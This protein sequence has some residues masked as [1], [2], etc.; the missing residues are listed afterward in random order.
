VFVHSAQ[1]ASMKR[2]ND[3]AMPGRIN[4][5]RTAGRTI[6]EAAFARPSSSLRRT[7]PDDTDPVRPSKHGPPDHALATPPSYAT[8]PKSRPPKTS[9]RKAARG[10]F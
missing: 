9:R 1:T 3:G 4:C 6:A 7:A 8:E 2:S 10:N 5:R